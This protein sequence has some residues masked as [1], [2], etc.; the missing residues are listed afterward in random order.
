MLYLR[1]RNIDR[2]NNHTPILSHREIEEHAHA[3]LKLY[4]PEILRDPGKICFRHFLESYCQMRIVQHEIYNE[5]PKRRIVAITAFKAIKIKIFDKENKCVR[6]ITIPARTVVFDNSVMESGME[7]FALFTGLHESGHIILQWHVYTGETFDGRPYDP[8]YDWNDIEPYVCCRREDIESKCGGDKNKIRTAKE[9]REHH[10]DFFAGAVAMPNATFRRFVIEAMREQG[11]YKPF[12]TFGRD[13]D[14]DLLADE[15]IP[16]EISEVYGV[17][18][19][20][21]RIKLRTSG[22]VTGTMS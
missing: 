13:D 16:F 14:L 18:K 22:F 15:I 21:A 8:D 20:A 2:V 1:P 4:K 3:V 19:R 12:I 5:D 11:Y 9:W 10:A 6:K 7:C 17:S